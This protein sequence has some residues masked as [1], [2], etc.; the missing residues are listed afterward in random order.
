MLESLISLLESFFINYGALGVFIGS[1]IE[2]IIAPIPSTIVILGSSLF[3][4]HELPLT[5]AS[6]FDLFIQISLPAALGMTIGSLVIY[7]L[8]YYLGKE[9]I[10][11]W[12]KYL[13]LNWEDI[14]KTNEKI[15]NEK[16]G[17]LFLFGV[18][19][20][21]VIPS[22]VISA[23][24]GVMRYDIKKYILITFLGGF[25]RASILGFIG[26]QFGSFYE[27]IS[28]SISSI[29]EIVGFIIIIIIVAIFIKRKIDEDK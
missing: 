2:E 15:E 24:C 5:L 11:R 16:R 17:G 13:T 10:V 26:W 22:V 23:F 3:M 27:S 4:L 19:A 6:F 18:R 25:V 12:G 14:E 9:F 21:P 29:E 20:I 7:F 28:T 8:C 1:I